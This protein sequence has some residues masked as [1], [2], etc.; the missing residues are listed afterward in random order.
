MSSSLDANFDPWAH[1]REHTTARIALGRAGGSMPTREVLAFAAAHAAARDAVH[2]AVNFDAV[3]EELRDLG[4]NCVRLDSAATDRRV[5]LQRPDLGR[6]L[7]VSSKRALAAHAPT[8]QPAPDLALIVADGLSAPAC[9]RQVT[10]LLAKLLPLLRRSGVKTSPAFLVR[11]G[12]VAIA[13]EIG[14]AIG[15]KAALILLGERPGLSSADS[16]GAY[17]VFDP[18]M[19]RTDAERNCVSNIRP[20]GLAF[21]AAASTLHYLITESMRK[22]LSGVRLKDN[23][24][25]RSPS[26]GSTPRPHIE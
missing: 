26:P 16:L 18:R 8:I 25:L 2:E 5:Y 9:Q 3:E 1:L 13:D 22:R 4:L 14:Q 11:H 23:R 15:A 20:A 6:Q 12:R 24:A 17:L 21:P 19:G 7:D 10:P